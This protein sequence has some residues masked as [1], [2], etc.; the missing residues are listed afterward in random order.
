MTAIGRLLLR[1]AAG[2]VFLFACEREA[3][4][5]QQRCFQPLAQFEGRN[6]RD[7]DEFTQ[8][9]VA[10]PP[11][12]NG[13]KNFLPLGTR[14]GRANID[15]YYV[16]FQRPP[17]MTPKAFFREIRLQFAV[18]AK[19]KSG[20]FAFG[21]YEASKEANDA[22]RAINDALWKS[23]SPKGA[24]MT[25]NLGGLFPSSSRR[26]GIVGIFEKAGDVQV[27]CSSDLDFVFST[28]ETVKGGMHP[29]AGFRGFGLLVNPGDL[30][31]TFYSKAVDRSSGTLWNLPAYQVHFDALFC[32]GHDFWVGFFGQLHRFLE[33]RNA[34]VGK[35][36]L[37]NHGPVKFPFDNGPYPRLDCAKLPIGERG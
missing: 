25:F 24:L 18:F 27:I 13:V 8:F 4:A 14:D 35:S 23:E 36:G 5:Q 34:K 6:A 26:T 19:G 11:K 37:D 33:T 31:W 20:N 2:A 29:V 15:F 12:A 3:F 16:T 28:V 17:G 21:P 7:F 32:L 10:L 1:A 22:V 9:E 30:T